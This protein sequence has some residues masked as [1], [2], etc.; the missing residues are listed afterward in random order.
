MT[1][2]LP[3][4]ICFVTGLVMLGACF[5]GATGQD[6]AD[7]EPRNATQFDQMFEDVSNWGRWGEDDDLGT[8]NLITPEKRRAAA[9]LVRSGISVSL[10]HNPMADEAVDNPSGSF[11][12]TM[13]EN[14]RSDT[15]L[16][17]YHGYAVS[18]IDALCHFQHNDMLFN[19]VPTS[20][21]TADG[22]SRL[23]IEH[24]KNGLVTRGILLDCP[25]LKGVPYLEPS[26]A[27]YVED[28]EAWEAEAGVEVSAGDVIF[29]YTGRWARR[30]ELGPWPLSEGSAGLHA[31]VVPW[32]KSRDVAIVGSDVVT[33]VIP[34]L[35][36]DVNLPVHTLVIAALGTNILDNVDLEALAETARSENRWE[37][38]LSVGPIPVTGG[39]GSPVNA[40][41]VF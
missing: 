3:A 17:S 9:G 18:H 23:G 32:L 16:F 36:D 1:T 12:H 6:P 28:I 35:V 2:R 15:L 11:E 21:S 41:A 24:L 29:V 30:A 40:L 26:T 27:I 37:F 8:A 39:T 20:A 5:S 10:S 7:R 34:S 25:R 13:A 14:R 4:I 19:G 31:S 22:C 33:D 38:M